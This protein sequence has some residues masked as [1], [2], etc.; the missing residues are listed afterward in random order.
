MLNPFRSEAEAYRF[1]WLTV[2]YFALIVAGAFINRWLGLGVFVGLSAGAVV[3]YLLHRER[4]E[5]ERTG[6]TLASSPDSKRVLV[7]AN[8]TVGGETLRNCIAEK[9]KGYRA[10]VLVVSPA[11][12]SPLR[13]WVSD[14][15]G[16]RD[17]ARERLD[18]SL[19]KLRAA[20]VDARGEVGDGEPLQAIEDAVRTFGPDEI[21]IST[22]PEGRSHW[23][24]KGVVSG[25]RARFTV[26]ITHVVVDLEREELSS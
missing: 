19:A 20:G 14:E 15:D 4:P 13:H 18:R 8:E 9:T 24:E 12:N 2:G 11:L 1:L 7:V 21:I 25:A 26:P 10:E 16:A 6:T 22:H 3:W 17:A 23:L 5:P